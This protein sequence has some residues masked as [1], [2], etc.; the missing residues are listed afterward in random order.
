MCL[1]VSC[2]EGGGED[3]LRIDVSH[4]WSHVEKE[5]G[6]LSKNRCVSCMVEKEEGTM[7]ARQDLGNQLAAEFDQRCCQS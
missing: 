7:V 1:M 6:G 3:F 5:K 2:G 4:A